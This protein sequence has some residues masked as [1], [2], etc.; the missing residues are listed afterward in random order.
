M[1]TH[2]AKYQARLAADDIL[3]RAHVANYA[4]VPRVV[5]CDPE[6]GAVGLTSAQARER[7]IDTVTAT[8]DLA[9]AFL[10]LRPATYGKDVGGRLGLVADRERGVLVGAWAAA[11]EAGEWIHLAVLA[12]RAQIPI[13]VLGDVIEQFP[14]FCEAYQTGFEQLPVRNPLEQSRLETVHG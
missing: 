11:P 3:G 5:F 10:I 6:V 9:H 2:V 13:A 4:A 1:Y 7:G 8:V 14:T 12:I